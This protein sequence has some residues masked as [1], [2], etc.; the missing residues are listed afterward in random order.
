MNQS[1]QLL[2][3]LASLA[4]A[5]SSSQFRLEASAP[6]SRSHGIPLLD[7]VG[8]CLGWL[9]T[10][11]ST[12]LDAQG[13]VLAKSDG[14]ILKHAISSD[15]SAF[16]VLEKTASSKDRMNESF[17][18]IRCF[19]RNGQRIGLYNFS[20]HRDDPL[21]QI[22]FNAA[23]SH[24][25]VAYPA[26]ARLIFLHPNGQVLHELPLFREAPYSNE[27]PLFIA[28]SMDTFAVLSQKTPS[29]NAITVAP[30]L[31]Y[32]SV[33]GEEQW[34][35]EL[36]VGTAGGL[37]ISDDGAWMAAGRYA[38]T[39][40][41]VESTISIFN[42]RG[43]LQFITEGLFRRAVF[44]KNG[45]RL[46]LMDRR[47]LRAIG[48]LQGELLW[49]VNLSRRTEM[50][51]DIAA[52]A[53]DDKTFALVAEN[54]FKDNRF[55]FEKARLLGFDAKG[56]QQH[57]ISLTVPLISPILKYSDNGNRLTLAAEGFLQ[58]FTVSQASK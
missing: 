24:L 58:N 48:I 43:A 23:G 46:L 38:V 42:F 45:S 20:Q 50:F 56:Q 1:I 52:A 39:G 34:R 2:L 47:Q 12:L 13:R 10:S 22:I 41:R 28:A 21:P 3:L 4:L 53:T 54:V 11:Q 8:S 37:A 57:E 15:G 35:R 31:I 7:Q 32:F 9:E 49:Q 36:P 5:Q 40:P 19:N 6:L 44:A 29:T 51:V 55:I 25:L 30:T 27:R 26:A 16:A 33:K 17:F 18:T 14:K